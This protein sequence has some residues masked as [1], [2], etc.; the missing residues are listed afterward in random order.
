MKPTPEILQRLKDV[1]GDKGFVVE[2]ADMAPYLVERRELYRGR[3]AAVVR[4][5]ST[6]EVSAVMRIAH[7][8]GVHVVPQGGNTGLVGGQIPDE[9]G[10]EILLSLSRM[11]AVRGIDTQNNT[12]TVDAGVTLAAA[13]AAAREADRLFP[14]S[15][16]SEGSC[17]I[18]GNLS[19]NAGGTQVLRY[20]NARDLV[21][22]LEVV[23][24]NG[25]VWDGLTGL[26]KDNTGYDLKQIFLGSEG[27][28]GIITGAVLKLFPMP[29]SVETAF[30]AVPSVEAA[31]KLL[32]VADGLAGGQ[33]SSFELVPRIGV[34]FVTRHIEGASDP[35]AEPYPWYVLIEMTAGMEDARLAET[36]EAA[37]AEGLDQGLVSDAAVARSEA[38]RADFWRLREALSDVQRA[39][40]GSIK[41]DISVPVSRMA[42][43]IAQAS[44]AVTA[45]LPGVRPVPFGHI[46]DGNV[47]FNLSQPVGADKAAFLALWGEMN[48]IVHGIVRGMGGSISAEH[49]VGRL[50]RDEIAATKSPVEMAAMRA[51]KRALDPKGIL[52]PGKVV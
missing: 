2:E 44:E 33:V 51:L 52:N 49:G 1:V 13:Q 6:A 9:S 36:M 14:L 5:A 15:L 48:G 3:A 34:E 4:P 32:R 11:N 18:G 42:D 35:L 43:F 31:V 24:A 41:H 26:R 19:T 20:G 30:A 8:T 16:A 21:L 50:K 29:L 37:L 38:Q 45:R 12:L 47:H 39:E 23:M 40:G 27:T 17:Q 22:G 10:E 7:E 46:G 28:L 25:D